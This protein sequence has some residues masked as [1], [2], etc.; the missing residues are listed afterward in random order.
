MNK[1]KLKLGYLLISAIFFTYVLIRAINV[2]VTHDEAATIEISNYS[3][4]RVLFTIVIANNHIP[5]T[6]LIKL[7]FLTGNDSLFIARLPSLLSFIPYLYFGYKITSKNLSGIIGL[8]C[9][10]LL[11]SNPFLL[12][13]FSL[14]RGYGLSLSFMLG[15]LYFASE[16]VK[17]FSPSTLSKSLI[18]G[19]LSVWAVFSMIYFFSALILILNLSTYL[20]KN[21]ELLRISLKQSAFIGL[22]TLLLIGMPLSRLIIYGELYYGGTDSFYSDTLVTLTQHSLSKNYRQET[23]PEVYIILNTLIV[24]LIG[25]ILISY[26]RSRKKHTHHSEN[27]FIAIT[28]L[29]ILLI[30]SAH[31]LAGIKYPIDRVALFFYPLFIFCLFYSLRNINKYVRTI[32]SLLVVLGFSL[33]LI[34]NHNTYKTTT[35]DFDAHN[36]EILKAINKIGESNNK[37]VTLQAEYAFIPP[38]N[39]YINRNSY[40]FVEIVRETDSGYINPVADYLLLWS[41]PGAGTLALLNAAG[42]DPSDIYDNDILIEYPEEQIVVFDLIKSK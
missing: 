23:A 2:G 6:I 32:I 4:L 16:N 37:L 13:F 30:T 26:L 12:E 22:S 14:A 35:W 9:F 20:K 24:V 29:I 10:F 34:I 27:F 5:Y 21:K 18:L 39:F 17:T 15:A 1:K 40:P 38:L 25:C 28:A 11:S 42:V 8:G 7:L 19:A 41:E 31:Y 3:F 33:N 36:E